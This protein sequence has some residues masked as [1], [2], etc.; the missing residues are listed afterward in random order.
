[1]LRGSRSVVAARASP[2]TAIILTA[3]FA[4]DF[5]ANARASRMAGDG[6][7]WTSASAAFFL[8]PGFRSSFR[9][10]HEDVDDLG[11][12]GRLL[13]QLARDEVDGPAAR[14]L[15]RRL[16]VHDVGEEGCDRA[17][18][19][20][21]RHVVAGRH[22]EGD[23]EPAVRLGRAEGDVPEARVLREVEPDAGD[24]DLPL[25]DDGESGDRGLGTAE[26]HRRRRAR[27]GE[28]EASGTGDDEG[29]RLQ[30][31]PPPGPGPERDDVAAGERLF[32]PADRPFPE[33]GRNLRVGE[34]DPLPRLVERRRV[35][36]AALA[37]LD[38][39]IGLGIPG[40]G[41]LA[42]RPGHG[43]L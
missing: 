30:R 7:I 38:V 34:R 39:R 32:H 2:S 31:G 25:R 26:R 17:V 21:S 23:R 22:V 40:A 9:V 12:G 20:P 35:P 10:L 16:R 4:S 13:A 18:L 42:G 5:R 43:D 37:G 36:A 14:P 19:G 1:M 3:G 15:G 41:R 8:T 6:G 28:Q 33:D 29:R 24:V 27:P 11:G